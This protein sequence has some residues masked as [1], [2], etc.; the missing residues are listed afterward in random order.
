MNDGLLPRRYAKALYKL[1]LER[2]DDKLIYDQLRE[3]SFRDTSVDELKRVV[4]NPENPAELK[5]A[6]ILNFLGFQPGTSLDDF[7]LMV[8]R[9]NRA[10]ILSMIAW[11]YMQLYREANNIARVEIVTASELPSPEVEAIINLVK[12][13]LGDVTLEIIQ[14]IDPELIGGFT[15]TINDLQLDASVRNE[16][17]QL[18]LHLLNK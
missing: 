15:V 14:E 16:L 9:K 2:G 4:F 12:K 13:R 1:A 6:A 10:N 11:S 18:R 3:F 5:G 8:I 7:L 17:R